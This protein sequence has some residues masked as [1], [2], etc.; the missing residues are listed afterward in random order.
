MECKY[1]IV[2]FA[3][4]SLI[5]FVVGGVFF[6]ENFLK[7]TASL[8]GSEG[9]LIRT[10]IQRGLLSMTVYRLPIEF[11]RMLVSTMTTKLGCPAVA[12]Q[13]SSFLDV[14]Y[15]S[16]FDDVMG[17]NCSVLKGKHAKVCRLIQSQS[18]AD[19]FPKL[20]ILS[21]SCFREQRSGQTEALSYR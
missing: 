15:N 3:L 8:N 9:S 13:Y 5:R 21:N 14:F 19:N 17:G 10:K 7:V 4:L 18:P 1:H 6:P 16:D 11:H 2:A 12:E 20:N